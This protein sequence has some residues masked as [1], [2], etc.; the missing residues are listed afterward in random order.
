MFRESAMAALA[1]ALDWIEAAGDEGEMTVGGCTGLG[2]IVH[3]L[4]RAGE[5]LD[6]A[7]LLDGARRAAAL[8]D[9][10]RISSDRLFDIVD[11]AAGGLLSLLVLHDITPDQAL[12]DAAAACGD[13]L[14]AA[15]LDRRGGWA[16]P[17]RSGQHLAGFAHG[18]AGIAAAFIRLSVVTGRAE[19]GEAAAHA[20]DF[21]S[22]LFSSAD[23]NWPIAEP[24]PANVVTIM[25]KMNAWCHG[26]P[27]ILVSAAT[28]AAAGEEPAIV[29]QAR[30]ALD[31]VER[32]NP[33]QADHLC[34]GHLGRADALLTGASR[35]GI[36]D[37][38]ARAHA[39]AER[40]LTRARSRQHFRLSTPGV[41]YLVFAAGFYRGLSGIGYQ[42]LRLAA[43]ARVR[44]I[45]FFG[46]HGEVPL[47][48][49]SG[50]LP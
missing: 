29:A 19:Y 22:S 27:G 12:V 8:I 14:I 11:G 46:A 7:R 31:T 50:I 28:M 38:A 6:E 9:R 13:H 10:A 5:L 23:R 43:P 35:L 41:E 44:S 20:L 24:D 3:G 37:A 21:V 34:C 33:V 17:S 26:A 16:W 1:P 2:S 18:S 39:A 32:W 49:A 36:P 45:L 4:A 30:G 47:Q 42:L 40:A 25:G 15:H 48:D